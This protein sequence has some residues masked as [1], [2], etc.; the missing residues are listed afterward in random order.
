MLAVPIHS[1]DGKGEG[2][3][4]TYTYTQERKVRTGLEEAII[5]SL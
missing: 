4:V 5:D 1:G 3:W 2:R